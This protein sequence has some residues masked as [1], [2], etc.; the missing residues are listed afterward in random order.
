MRILQYMVCVDVII[1]M[2]ETKR[3]LLRQWKLEDLKPFYKINSHEEVCKY[4]PKQ[5]NEFES[6]ILAK[7][8]IQKFDDQGFG[9]FALEEKE[10][11]EFIGFTGLNIPSFEAS[12]MPAVEIGWRLAVDYWGKGLATEAALAVSD[13][14]FFELKLSE[15]VSFTVPENIASRRVMEKIGMIYDPSADFCHPDLPSSHR[16]NRHVLYVKRNK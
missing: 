7:K 15:I 5:L 2:I 6:N 14:A 13:Y 1:N 11:K 12:F 10:N 3:L 16:L 8:I 4:L 9:L